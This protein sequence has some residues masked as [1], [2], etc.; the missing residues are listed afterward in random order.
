MR[1]L[2][3]TYIILKP[4]TFMLLPR[5]KSILGNHMKAADHFMKTT[6]KR[7]SHSTGH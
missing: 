4:P 5:R 2:L 3:S 7:L 1:Q 6:E